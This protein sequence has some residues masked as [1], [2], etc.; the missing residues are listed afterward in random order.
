MR[1][2]II[3]LSALLLITFITVSCKKSADNGDTTETD[4][5]DSVT[6]APT[7]APTE[8]PSMAPT[9]APTTAPAG[10]AYDVFKDGTYTVKTATDVENYYVEAT[11]T[12]ENGKVTVADWT[13]YDDKA[14]APF[15]AEYYKIFESQGADPLYVQQAKDDWSGS[16]GYAPKFIEEQNVN[17]VDAVSAATWSFVEFEK[18]IN[19]ALKQATDGI[20]PVYKDGVYDGQ[21]NVDNDKCYSKATITVEGGKIT[22]VDWGI[23][24]SGRKDHVF[25]SDYVGMISGWE[26]G[27]VRSNVNGMGGYAKKLI[28]TQN[29]YQVDTVSGATWANVKFR[30]AVDN[31]LSKSK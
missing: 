25:D 20:V 13:A 30:Q 24:D 22:K 8:T 10:S 18:V 14:K 21:S 31:A 1:K 4:S 5:K 16:R 23:Y 9:M 2:R 11:V 17:K 15:D 28:E 29:L 6:T 12:I 7:T 26:Q 3:M 19:L 27:Q